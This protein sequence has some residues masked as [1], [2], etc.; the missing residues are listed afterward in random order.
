[1]RSIVM[2]LFATMLAGAL[3]AQ[4]QQTVL[5]RVGPEG[6]VPEGAQQVMVRR[7]PPAA[8]RVGDHAELAMT[9]T[10]G[11][12][13]ISA[14]VN[15]KGPFRFGVDTG[16]SGYL[17]LKAELAATLG[18]EPVGEARAGDPSGRNPVSVK[19]YSVDSVSF[20]G[21]DYRGVSASEIGITGGPMAELDGI[22]GIAF[23]RDILLTL[24]FGQGRL[25][26][27]AGA[28]PEPNGKDIVPVSLEPSGLFNIPLRIG[29]VEETVH[30]DTGNGRQALFVPE[31]TVA[32]LAVTGE[33]RRLGVARTVSQ[34][35]EIQGRDLAV[36]VTIGTTR[37]PVT[38]VAYPSI[39]V[40][41]LGSAALAGMAITLDAQNQRVRVVPSAPTS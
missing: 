4:A 3:P 41:N 22:I 32:R 30:L 6:P 16:A 40:G 23:F 1:M 7:A 14:M 18:L 9:L 31:G 20:G 34:E 11:I 38:E 35:I 12:P 15:G 37:L 39:T 19:L 13:T 5:R 24:D 36:P 29:A 25:I 27:A 33:P 26:A 2:G 28:L 21:L 8:E 10:A 17:I